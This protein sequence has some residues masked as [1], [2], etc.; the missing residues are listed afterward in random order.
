MKPLTVP[1]AIIISVI[2]VVVG[3]LTCKGI[4]PSSLIIGILGWLIP[5]PIQ[6][7]KE[8]SNDA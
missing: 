7:T 6:P 4:V 3:V 1:Q 8:P 2:T 5:S